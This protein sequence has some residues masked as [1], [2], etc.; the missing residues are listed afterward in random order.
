MAWQL[1]DAK[2]R[3]S[4][5][6]DSA[7]TD[8]PQVVT[9]HGREVAVVL[10]IEDYRRL[11]GA[12]GG[13]DASDA[14]GEVVDD[15]VERPVVAG[16]GRV[17]DR[18]VQPP[19]GPVQSDPAA[20]DGELFVRGIAHGDHHVLRCADVVDVARRDGDQR[21]VVPMCRREGPGVNGRCGTGARGGRRY[22]A[23]V[24]PQ[25]GRELG[26]C[27]VVR[28]DED[29]PGRVVDRDRVQR[30]EGAVDE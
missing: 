13:G 16:A 28:A 2:Q 14:V 29:H 19:G 23:A 27:G 3:F 18:P 8:G 24:G 12:D 21:N 7:R 25:G 22:R 11:R 26:A 5:L 30:I 1:Q 15:P 20:S 10:S 6:V 17:G 9:R 4:R